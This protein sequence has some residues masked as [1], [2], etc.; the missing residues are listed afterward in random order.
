MTRGTPALKREPGDAFSDSLIDDIEAQ[1]T[2]LNATFTQGR[3]LEPIKEIENAEVVQNNDIFAL[4]LSN[5]KKMH[6]TN[7]RSKLNSPPSS[8][9]KMDTT[10]SRGHSSMKKRP[11][12]MSMN[13]RLNIPE[14]SVR[15]ED[16]QRTASPMTSANKR[17][18]ANKTTLQSPATCQRASH[19]CE[20]IYACDEVTPRALHCGRR[21]P[22]R[23]LMSSQFESRKRYKQNVKKL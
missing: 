20:R 3:D 11:Q 8:I 1:N 18:G 7:M 13:H 12:T 16:L 19:K 5:K 9:N 17:A 2:M 10:V 22:I 21:E 6:T 14:Q 4:K 15:F 23:N